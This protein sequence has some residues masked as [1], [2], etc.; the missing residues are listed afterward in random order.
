MSRLPL[1]LA[2]A[3]FPKL[4]L[5]VKSGALGLDFG[6][7]SWCVAGLTILQGQWR[8]TDVVVGTD[9]WG[10]GVANDT[11]VHLK[12]IASLVVR[13]PAMLPVTPS[14]LAKRASDIPGRPSEGPSP[15]TAPSPAATAIPSPS[16]NPTPSAAS[17]PRTLFSCP[18]APLP[19]RATRSGSGN[20]VD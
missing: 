19:L 4:C 9:C 2:A 1:I 3:H 6:G 7:V 16:G 12:G 18:A 11:K 5:G 17:I 14:P 13:K 20:L 10:F 15:A 8:F